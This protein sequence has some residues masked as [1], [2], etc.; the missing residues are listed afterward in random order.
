MS[1]FIKYVANALNLLNEIF[2]FAIFDTHTKEL[3]IA[4]NHFGV[5]PLYF[6]NDGISFLFGS[7]I[8]SFFPFKTNKELSYQSFIN[9]FLWS[10]GEVNPFKFVKKL[11]PGS[12]LKL[13]VNDFSSLQLV[14]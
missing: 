9:I 6:Y 2:A 10:P 12:Y 8:K 4:R 1:V 5:K 11:L 3:Y 13:N 14:F 7:E